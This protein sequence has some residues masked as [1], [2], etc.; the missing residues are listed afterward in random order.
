MTRRMALVAVCCS[1]ASVSSRLRASI[2]SNSLRILDGDDGLIGKRRHQFDLLVRVRLDALS[3][4]CNHADQFARAKQRNAE[5]GAQIADL[6]VILIEIFGI[7]LD[8]GNDC[9]STVLAVR[10]TSELL[11]GK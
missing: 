8:I 1:S 6:S 9:R 7:G 3:G 4:E 5:N 11:P 10:P 2:S